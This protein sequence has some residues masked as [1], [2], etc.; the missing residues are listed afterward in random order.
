MLHVLFGPDSFSRREALEKLKTDLDQDGMLETNTLLLDATQSK[1]A[2][3]VA[4][5][6]AAPFFG[7]HR[8]VIVEGLLA[9]TA[10]RRRG[11]R[12]KRRELS[13]EETDGPWQ[14]LM[15]Y[16]DRMPE[17][18]VLVL[19][20]GDV[21]GGDLP[22]SL[23]ARGTVERFELPD[24]RAVATWIQRR[25]QTLGIKVAGQAAK[26]MADLIGNDAWTLASELDKLAAHSAGGV[27]REEDVRALVSQ[28]R[29]Q[30]GYLLA[31]AVADGREAQ[32][33]KLL[34][35]LYTQGHPLAVLLSTIEGRYR[36]LAVAREMLDA[37][38]SDNKIGEQLRASGYGLQ[39]LVEQASRHPAAELRAALTYIAQADADIKRG[40]YDEDLSLELLLHDLC[41]G[42]TSRAA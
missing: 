15:D 7:S 41:T 34:Y 17:T 18:T 23:R 35:E 38:A 9:Q 10:Q 14:A 25:A 36:R 4:A 42:R 12:S 19:I 33:V 37:G 16:V 29:E 22:A 3:V 8:L 27:I 30:H 21:S 26:L 31:D 40:V 6:D 11:R 39:R 1:V 24:Q 5:C 32:A 2:E 13:S 28:M 20:D